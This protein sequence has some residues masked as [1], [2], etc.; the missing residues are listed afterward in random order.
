MPLLL[1]PP[2]FDK[3]PPMPVIEQVLSWDEVQALCSR[4][5]GQILMPGQFFGGCS[6]FRMKDGVKICV[7]WYSGDAAV[8]RHERAHCSGWGPDHKGGY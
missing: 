6:G 1:P 2:E 8:L 5:T 4:N 7:I 3:P